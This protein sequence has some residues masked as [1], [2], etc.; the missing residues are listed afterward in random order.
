MKS[1]LLDIISLCLIVS[2]TLLLGIMIG[3]CINTIPFASWMYNW[4][5]VDSVVMILF[6]IAK[7]ILYCRGAE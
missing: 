1:F 3:Y 4:I 6:W 7:A 5:I 2:T